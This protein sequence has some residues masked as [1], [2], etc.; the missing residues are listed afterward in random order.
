[1]RAMHDLDP[2]L[3]Q[4][5]ERAVAEIPVPP[6]PR[7]R[8]ASGAM[9][10]GLGVI[11]ATT[12]VLVAALG[13]GRLLTDARRTAG[14]APSTSAAGASCPRTQTT[15]ASGVVTRDGVFGIEGDTLLPADEDLTFRLLRRGANIGE[16]ITV[17]FDQLGTNAPAQWVEYSVTASRQPTSWGTL[18]FAL[19][20]K[21][22]AFRNSCWRLLV[23]GADTGLV[24]AVG[25]R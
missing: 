18:A 10:S 4:F 3:R 2:K 14:S 5:T 13:A 21:P 22:I 20:V 11:L 16:S 9:S 7:G 1:M 15:D 6:L 17:R 25:E 19:A 8:Q 23:N 12:V 24:V